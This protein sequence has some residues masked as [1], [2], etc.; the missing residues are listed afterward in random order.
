MSYRKKKRATNDSRQTVLTGM[1]ADLQSTEEL[2]S[3]GELYRQFV[4]LFSEK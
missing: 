2:L 4:A 3:T 1:N